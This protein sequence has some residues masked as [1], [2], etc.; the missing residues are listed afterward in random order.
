VNVEPCATNLAEMHVMKSG[1]TRLTNLI[2]EDSMSPKVDEFKKHIK[3]F[4]SG[5]LMKYGFE[6]G[7]GIGKNGQG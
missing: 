4:G 5:Y 2:N 1:I 7:K 3:G 6:K